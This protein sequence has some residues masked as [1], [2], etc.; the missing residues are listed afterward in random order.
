MKRMTTTAVVTALALTGGVTS[1]STAFGDEFAAT[2]IA[3]RNAHQ[4]KAVVAEIDRDPSAFDRYAR[5]LA[6][7][8]AANLITG[9]KMTSGNGAGDPV[10]V[11]A[12]EARK[13]GFSAGAMRLAQESAA[14]SNA[15][16]SR[17]SESEPSISD[18]PISAHASSPALSAFFAAAA[19]KEASE[20]GAVASE[21]D[22]GPLGRLR[23]G[24]YLDPKPSQAAP[25]KTLTRPNPETTLRSWGYHPT[26]GRAGGGWTR[27]QSWRSFS[28]GHDTFR[29]HALISGK[30][31]IREQNY[32]G[33]PPGEPNPEVWRSG[34]WP[35]ADWPAYV[36]WWHRTH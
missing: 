26:P 33:S 27:P 6:R 25:W 24:W 23:C 9:G 8:H 20:L 30:N 4:S 16:T 35:Y 15:L 21:Q 13:R 19:K 3:G 1:A 32:T 28:C 14:L 22:L 31:K 10:R 18:D 7:M 34:P 36:F 17:L 2:A 5:E 11:L 29:D 12:R